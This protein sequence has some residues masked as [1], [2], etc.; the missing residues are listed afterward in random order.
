M[1]H[2][3]VIKTFSSYKLIGCINLVIRDD[4]ASFGEVRNNG[5]FLIR[6]QFPCKTLPFLI[7]M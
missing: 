3:C 1:Y 4:S 2:L 5:R 7:L 6:N